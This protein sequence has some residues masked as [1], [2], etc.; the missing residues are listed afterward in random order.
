MHPTILA[1]IALD[2]VEERQR[3]GERLARLLPRRVPPAHG[4]A[5]RGLARALA[6]VARWLDEELPS[7]PHASRWA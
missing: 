6:G 7:A 3:R 2:V 1:T 5:R 4:A